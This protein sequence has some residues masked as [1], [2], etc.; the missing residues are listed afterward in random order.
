MPRC[1]PGPECT[2][3]SAGGP[4]APLPGVRGAPGLGVW[5]VQRG[6]GSAALRVSAE[7]VLMRGGAEGIWARR[8]GASWELG[9]QE[10]G[11]SC[12]GCGRLVSLGGSAAPREGRVPIS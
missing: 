1:K 11:E 10:L 6:V 4:G 12:R 8:R 3:G 7:L 5:A 2:A 9:L